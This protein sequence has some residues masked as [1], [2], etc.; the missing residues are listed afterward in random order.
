MAPVLLP[1]THP[2]LTVIVLGFV[3]YTHAIPSD[4]HTH[5]VEER[6]MISTEDNIHEN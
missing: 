5:S 4:S 1:D 2:P 6:S 3:D